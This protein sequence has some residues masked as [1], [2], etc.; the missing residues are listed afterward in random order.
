M[1]GLGGM[2]AHSS[3]RI[4]DLVTDGLGGMEGGLGVE[5]GLGMEGWFL[6]FSFLNSSYN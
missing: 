3:W 4:T 1:G 5:G 6:Y 2:S